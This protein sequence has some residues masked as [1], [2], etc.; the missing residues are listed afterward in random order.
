M[1]SLPPPLEEWG[2]AKTLP[3][4]GTSLPSPLRGAPAGTGRTVPHGGAAA[5]YADFACLLPFCM[6]FI[7]LTSNTRSWLPPIGIQVLQ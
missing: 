6:A 3:P 4:W 7:R 1:P 5:P 2:Q